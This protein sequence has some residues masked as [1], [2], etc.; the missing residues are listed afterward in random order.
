MRE[1]RLNPPRPV[2]HFLDLLKTCYQ[3]NERNGKNYWHSK[4][5]LETS[6]LVRGQFLLISY[7]DYN[8]KAYSFSEFLLFEIFMKK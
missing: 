1:R 8:E 7:F 3:L 2:T 4:I 5:L 6:P